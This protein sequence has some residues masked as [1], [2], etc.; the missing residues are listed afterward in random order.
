MHRRLKFAIG[1]PTIRPQYRRKDEFHKFN[2]SIRLNHQ[3]IL[4]D[5]FRGL[6]LDNDVSSFGVVIVLV[7]NIAEAELPHA[8]TVGAF[9]PLQRRIEMVDAPTRAL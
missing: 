9:Q 7:E 4:P 3:F 2:R 5:H 1:D 6:V 8:V